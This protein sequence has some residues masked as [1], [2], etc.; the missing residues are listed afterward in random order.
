M[1]AFYISIYVKLIRV[2]MLLF[3]ANFLCNFKDI[4]LISYKY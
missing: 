4:Y 1:I 2:P 3:C